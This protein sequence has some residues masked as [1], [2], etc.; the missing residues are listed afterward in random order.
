MSN[1]NGLVT[2]STYDLQQR[3]LSRTVGNETTSL[4]YDNAGQVIQL[5]M[6]DASTLN[7]TY[8]AAHRLT[9]VQDTL[10]NKVTYTLDAE[11]N[12]IN[13]VTTDPLGGLAKTITR[14]YDALNRLQQV[15]GVE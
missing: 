14:S 2:T 3:L 12:R 4:V 7:Y 15:M 6:P 9:E 10:G 5:V 11:G 1:P 13:E 8:D